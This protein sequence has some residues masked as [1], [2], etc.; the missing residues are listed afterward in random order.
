VCSSSIL[1]L[2][3]SAAINERAQ[4]CCSFQAPTLRLAAGLAAELGM[5]DA[6]VPRIRSAKTPPSDRCNW[7]VTVTTPE[8]PL[9]LTV[10][11]RWEEE[12]LTVQQRWPGCSF[13]GWKTYGALPARRCSAGAGR[14][15]NAA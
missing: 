10:L 7:I 12:L 5:V 4:L 15:R 14:E 13:L 3:P 9:A 11:S 1:H 6:H 2:G 8:I